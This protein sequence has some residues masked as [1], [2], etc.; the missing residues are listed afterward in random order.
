M[1]FV[2]QKKKKERKEVIELFK[3]QKLVKYYLEILLNKMCHAHPSIKNY[4]ST[5]PTFHLIL[6]VEDYSVN[7]KWWDR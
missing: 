1:F 3:K 6:G 7:R 4:L 2:F 5:V